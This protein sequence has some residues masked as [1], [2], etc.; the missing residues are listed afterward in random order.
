MALDAHSL[1]QLNHREVLDHSRL[2]CPC[3]NNFSAIRI[4]F[5]YHSFRAFLAYLSRFKTISQQN[6]LSFRKTQ[7]ILSVDKVCLVRKCNNGC[8]LR[9][10]D[11]HSQANFKIIRATKKTV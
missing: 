9:T 2:S 11:S 7:T 10:D 1:N 5:N 6:A 8:V 3:F 4:N